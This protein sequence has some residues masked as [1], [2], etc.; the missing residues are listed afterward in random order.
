MASTLLT[1]VETK[2]YLR[3]AEAL[4]SESEREGIVNLIASDPR[5][6]ELIVG[7]GGWRKVRIALAGRGKRGGA[8]VIYFFHSAAI[9][10]YIAAIFAKN[11]RANLSRAEINAL[12]KVGKAIVKEH[13]ERL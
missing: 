12:A 8:R 4:L 6:G 3:D 13:G 2:H 1:V 7:S 5:C 10:A 11:E 9:P